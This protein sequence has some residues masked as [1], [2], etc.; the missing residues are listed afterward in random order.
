MEFTFKELQP[1]MNDTPMFKSA[2]RFLAVSY[3]YL[4]ETMSR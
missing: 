4:I 1:L 2:E 3:V